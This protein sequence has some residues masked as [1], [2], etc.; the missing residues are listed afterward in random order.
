MH[1]MS[2]IHFFDY[3][4]NTT[5]YLYDK[6]SMFYYFTTSTTKY[7]YNRVSSH[8]S[9]VREIKSFENNKFVSV[10]SDYLFDKL[11]ETTNMT[12]QDKVY[13][14][15]YVNFDGNN[16]NFKVILTN[17]S[18]LDLHSKLSEIE[19]NKIVYDFIMLDDQSDFILSDFAI[20]YNN[21]SFNVTEFA[22]N[23]I[24]DN[25]PNLYDVLMVNDVIKHDIKLTPEILANFII[26]IKAFVDFEEV[27]IV[28]PLE[29]YLDLKL[30]NIKQIIN[31]YKQSNQEFCGKS[32]EQPIE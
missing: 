18:F 21:T 24:D 15:L 7:L 4:T 16:R 27:Y 1:K 28:V 20:E 8:V 10:Y 14:K 29:T 11:Y 17:V 5:S 31:D 6:A 13:D 32:I 12:R 22:Q 25:E 26:K 9:N 3:V 30:N 23:L 2:L 19:N